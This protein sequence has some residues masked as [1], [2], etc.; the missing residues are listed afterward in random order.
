MRFQ[1]I[2]CP[3]DFSPGAEQALRVAVRIA[4]EQG[5]ELVIAHAT[6]LPSSV[7]AGE[8][9][10]PPDAIQRLLEEEQRELEGATRSAIELGAQRVSS[11]F[12]SG[13]PWAQIVEALDTD[14]A[15]DLVVMGTQGRS[16]LSRVLLGSVAEKVV[17]HA[18]C[19]VLAVRPDSKLAPYTN[20]LCPIDFSDTSQHAVE[21]AGALTRPGGTGITLLHVIEAPVAFSGEPLAPAFLQD[22]SKRSSELLEQ[23]ASRLRE[24]VSVA[25]VTRSRLGNPGSQTLA[26]LH[27][28]RTFDLVAMGSHGRTGLRRALI[29][30]V[31]EKVV[32]HAPCA[33]LVARSPRGAD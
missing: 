9:P 2:L 15:F 3:T 28:D 23:W 31:A 17:R 26:V 29:G 24:Q 16:G 11:Q 14:P 32:R 20:V 4:T 19:P 22:L 25:V 27:E 7:F 8:L 10:F 1:K 21:L 5:A 30:S 33:V 12:L 18:R 6:Y 13:Q